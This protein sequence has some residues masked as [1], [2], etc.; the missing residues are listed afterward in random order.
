M[1]SEIR[2]HCTGISLIELVV[3]I[4]VVAIGIGG[5]VATYS[6]YT[7]SSVDPIVRKQALAV[8]ESLLEE[9]ALQPFTY[10]DP[11]DPAVYTATSATAAQCPILLEAIGPEAGQTRTGA[12]PFNN[13]NDYNGFAMAGAGMTDITGAAVPSLAAY[14]ASVSIS[15]STGELPNLLSNSDALRI[16]VTV[17]GPAG[18]S[19]VLQGYRLQYAPNQP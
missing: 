3:F 1:S 17:T 5:V 9:A 19:V 7:M 18:V 10:C 14:S 15:A 11:T 16:V 13:V 4:V 8:A 12:N 2:R 6:Q